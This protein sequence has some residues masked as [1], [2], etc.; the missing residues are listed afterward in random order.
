MQAVVM[1]QSRLGWDRHSKYPA[2]LPQPVRRAPPYREELRV[3][4]S[5][6][7]VP[8]PTSAAESSP[9]PVRDWSK[10]EV[11]LMEDQ[12]MGRSFSVSSQSQSQSFVFVRL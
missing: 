10:T 8:S 6:F 1:G 4:N 5:E 2:G 11:G 12:T 9:G 7:R 3:P